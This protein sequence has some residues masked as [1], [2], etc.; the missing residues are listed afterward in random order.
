[1]HF[2][3]VTKELDQIRVG[4][5]FLVGGELITIN[6][7]IKMNCLKLLSNKADKVIISKH[8]THW[9]FGVRRANIINT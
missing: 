6:E 1:M 9:F 8:K 3:K 2:F 5:S 4:N 7:A